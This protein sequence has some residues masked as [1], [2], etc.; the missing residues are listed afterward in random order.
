M[1]V[2]MLNKAIEERGIKQKF[3]ADAVGT[4]ET[5]LS[6]MLNGKQKMDVNTFFAITQAMR[7]TPDEI[8]AFRKGA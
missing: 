4:S 5:A 8:L 2:E 1:I 7:M 3:I 6:M